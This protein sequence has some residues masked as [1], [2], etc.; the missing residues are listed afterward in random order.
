M[1]R[2]RAHQKTCSECWPST[3]HPYVRDQANANLQRRAAQQTPTAAAECEFILGFAT[4]KAL[5]DDAEG[6]DK[7]GECLETQ[8]FN[9][10]NGDALQQ[11]T[12]GLL[13][14]R[15][16]DN[17]TAFTDGYR[18]WI[19]GPHGLQARLNTEQFDWEQPTPSPTPTPYTG[20]GDWEQWERSD[21]LTDEQT[22]GVWLRSFDY[23]DGYLYVRCRYNR[24]EGRGSIL[25]VFI[26][27]NT[28]LGSETRQQVLTRADKQDV[29][30]DRWSLSTDEEA[31]FAPWPAVRDKLIDDMKRASRLAARVV[32]HDDTTITA[33]WDIAG[34]GGSRETG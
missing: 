17:W 5:I 30:S 1:L 27:W 16:A 3:S 29:Q 7:V 22:I 8:R 23:D 21:P 4:L 14:W 12:G 11:T 6:P 19:N 13:V 28:Y 20:T 26:D 33:Q 2:T 9:P 34:F 25:E 32:K 10:E 15:K 31:T 18:T 24:P